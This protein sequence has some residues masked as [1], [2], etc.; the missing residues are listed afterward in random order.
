LPAVDVLALPP[1]YGQPRLLPANVAWSYRGP[2]GAAVTRP[3]RQVALSIEDTHPPAALKL[4]QLQTPPFPPRGPAIDNV[5][6]RG[7]QQ[8]PNASS[9]SSRCLTSSS[10]TP[11]ASS[12]SVSPT[13]RWSRCQRTPT[14][15]S[16]SPRARSPGSSSRAR[17]SSRS[18]PA[19]PR[20]P[21][22]TCTSRGA[23]RMRSCSPVARG[24]L[25]PA[26]DIPDR[27]P[28]SSFAPS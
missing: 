16:R 8:P 1:L 13:S 2:A 11:T 15:T 22:R 9:A 23:C 10:S 20:T 7:T 24:V 27:T 14:A 17:R 19:T 28:A 26:T 12:I 6:L 25:A 3:A 5:W 18:P 4:P 21:R